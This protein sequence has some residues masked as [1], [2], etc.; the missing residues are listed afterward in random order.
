[1]RSLP[2]LFANEQISRVSNYHMRGETLF[3][4]RIYTARLYRTKCNRARPLPGKGLPLPLLD[5]SFMFSFRIFK[6]KQ[7]N[8]SWLEKSTCP[9][10]TRVKSCVTTQV[11]TIQCSPHIYT[12]AIWK[13]WITTSKSWE[14][15]HLACNYNK[16]RSRLIAS[17]NYRRL[18]KI[19]NNDETASAFEP[20][21][22]NKNKCRS[23]GYIFNTIVSHLNN[24]F[25]LCIFNTSIH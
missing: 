3:F 11:K 16:V 13:R 2:W 15:S 22:L 9:H 14:G 1:M 23:V 6:I 20:K 7:R 19:K 18:A 8:K 5:N 25:P 12:C 10:V 21:S 4:T 17:C 24:C